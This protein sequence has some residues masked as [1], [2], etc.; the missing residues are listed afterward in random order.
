M[1]TKIIEAEK[2][3]KD[4]DLLVTFD[5]NGYRSGYV[6]M[7]PSN[8]FHG[9]NHKIL[10]INVFGNLC[11]SLKAE[12]ALKNCINKSKYLS[13]NDW[14]IGFTTNHNGILQDYISL[15]KYFPKMYSNLGT[16]EIYFDME[17]DYWKNPKSLTFVM[18]ECESIACKLL[19]I[20]KRLNAI[21]RQNEIK[22]KS[23]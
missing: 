7:R 9:V 11:F 6:G 12:D 17:L 5:S 23:S 13:Y 20:E 2:I 16:Q 14:V 10:P 21:H 15:K 8:I 4:F 3:F 19:K 18:N 22:P 1:G